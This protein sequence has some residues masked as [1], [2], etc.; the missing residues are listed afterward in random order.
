MFALRN[1]TNVRSTSADGQP[2]RRTEL[3][4]TGPHLGN[5][6]RETCDNGRAATHQT[7]GNTK[8]DQTSSAARFSIRLKP[9]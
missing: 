5:I 6:R 9:D 3:R 8:A 2:R 1:V 7:T 4:G